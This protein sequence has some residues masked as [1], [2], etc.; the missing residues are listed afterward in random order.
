MEL[1]GAEDFTEDGTA[2]L[3][4]EGT[5]SELGSFVMGRG[6]T[7]AFPIVDAPRMRRP[8]ITNLL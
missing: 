6:A 8:G 2:K 3:E 5:D 4:G 1:A 7:A